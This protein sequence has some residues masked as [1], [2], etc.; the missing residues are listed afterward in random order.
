M[1]ALLVDGSIHGA[2]GNTARFLAEVGGLLAGRG[3]GAGAVHLAGR[4]DAGIAEAI[5]QTLDADLVVYGSGTYW[6][7]WGSPLQRYL[8][9]LTE[10]ELGDG[11]LGKPAAVLVTMDSVGGTSVAYRLQGVLSAL[12]FLIP[13]ASAVVLSRVGAMVRHPDAVLPDGF[14][15]PDDVWS[16]A[17]LEAMVANLAAARSGG[18]WTRWPVAGTA[19]PRWARPAP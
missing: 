9:L 1:N 13:P 7:S 6:D 14:D 8:E 5:R 4:G 19:A 11:L 3:I 12:G 16:E 17:D 18:G 2:S 15:P 10:H